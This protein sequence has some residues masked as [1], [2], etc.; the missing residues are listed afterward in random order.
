MGLYP[1]KA[2]WKLCTTSWNST[3]WLWRRKLQVFYMF[4]VPC[5]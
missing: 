5:I 2:S 1:F 4:H 3:I